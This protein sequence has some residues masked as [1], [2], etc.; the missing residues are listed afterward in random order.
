[1]VQTKTP[2]QHWRTSTRAIT[3]VFFLL[4]GIFIA[5]CLAVS[6][7]SFWYLCCALLWALTS[8]FWF[9]RPGAAARV[10]IFPVIGISVFLFKTRHEFAEQSPIHE[11]WITL[12]FVLAACLLIALTVAK[13]RS[14]SPFPLLAGL[15]YVA[16]SIYVDSRFTN[17]V[18]IRTYEMHWSA[19]GEVPWGKTE[20]VAHPLSIWRKVGGSDCSDDFDSEV[21]RNLVLSANRPT[22][23]VQYNVFRTFGRVSGSNVRSVDGYLLN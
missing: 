10:S 4:S 11:Y 14:I 3:G 21:L 8:V 13:A 19:N 17:Q 7:A 23:T 5:L 6:D 22:V 18:E 16:L 9:A 12:A 2:P 15:A 20:E 1:M